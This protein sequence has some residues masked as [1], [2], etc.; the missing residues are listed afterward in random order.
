MRGLKLLAVVFLA[1]F[2]SALEGPYAQGPNPVKHVTFNGIFNAELDHNLGIWAPNKPGSYPVIYFITGLAGTNQIFKLKV[3][4][5]L[6]HSG[7]FQA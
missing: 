3:I 1:N 7:M 4:D 6:K 5:R 2:C